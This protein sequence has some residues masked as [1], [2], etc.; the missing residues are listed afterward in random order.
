MYNYNY[1][2]THDND[3][4]QHYGIKG[5]KWGVRKSYNNYKAKKVAKKQAKIDNFNRNKDSI[6]NDPNADKGAKKKVEYLEK[7]KTQRYLTEVGKR[8]VTQLIFDSMTGDIKNYNLNNKAQ[9]GK[10]STQILFDS[11]VNTKKNTAR[12]TRDIERYD[13]YN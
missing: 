13:R 12:Y 2:Y 9:L 5:M 11:A 7:S 3:Y 10:Q 1:N 4:L 6:K 8:V